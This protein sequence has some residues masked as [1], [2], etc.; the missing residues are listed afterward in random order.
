MPIKGEKRFK[1]SRPEWFKQK[2]KAEESAKE[3]KEENNMKEIMGIIGP[4]KV[5]SHVVEAKEDAKQDM[6]FAINVDSI[7][8]VL[9]DIGGSRNVFFYEVKNDF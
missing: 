5:R 3:P 8:R 6:A 4:H 1:E 9:K 7:A 2:P